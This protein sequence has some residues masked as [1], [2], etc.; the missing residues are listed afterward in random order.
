MES[1]HFQ[2]LVLL[3]LGMILYF[4][5]GVLAQTERQTCET[6][7]NIFKSYQFSPD[8]DTPENPISGETD[9]ENICLSYF[10]FGGKLPNGFLF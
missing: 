8:I 3:S 5:Q 7:S 6:V 9:G 4:G 2:R 10:I 1:I